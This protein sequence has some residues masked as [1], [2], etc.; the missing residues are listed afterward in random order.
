MAEGSVKP[1][2]RFLT[3]SI[4]QVIQIRNAI[5]PEAAATRP[6]VRRRSCSGL[7]SFTAGG[8][9]GSIMLLG[10]GSGTARRR[11]GSLEAIAFPSGVG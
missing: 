7:I 9:D 1:D 2:C 6:P 5:T 10:W 8:A 3:S 11:A 4:T